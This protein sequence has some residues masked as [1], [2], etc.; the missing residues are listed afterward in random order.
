MAGSSYYTDIPHRKIKHGCLGEELTK[1]NFDKTQ[2]VLD[3]IKKEYNGNYR[4][5][6]GELQY[7]FI[8]FLLGENYES[9]EQ[10]KRLLILLTTCDEMPNKLPGFYFDLIPV[11]YD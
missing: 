3:L 11:I 4:V 6:F 5:L 1:L 7:S 10:W 9:F 8:K 2:I